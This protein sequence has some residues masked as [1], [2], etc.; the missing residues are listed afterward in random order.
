M[1]KT[2]N[3]SNVKCETLNDLFVLAGKRDL[4]NFYEQEILSYK[5]DYSKWSFKKKI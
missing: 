2:S 5:R 4:K 1:K 3:P